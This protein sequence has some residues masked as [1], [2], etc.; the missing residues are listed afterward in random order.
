VRR[1][2]FAIVFTAAMPF[3]YDAHAGDS[4]LAE[5]L[6]RQGR[7]L[8][9]KG[10]YAA[11][12][13]RL[14]ESY[15][16][17]PSTGTLLA[18]ALC[19]ER[20]GK[21]ASA[22]ASYAEVVT[23]SKR[24]GNADRERAAREHK[25][26]L[27]PKLSRLTIEVGADAAAASELVVTRD[28]HAVGQGA[29]GAPTPLDPGDHVVMATA[30]GKQA[31]SKTVTVG[32]A[33]DS[34][35]VTVPPLADLAVAATPAPP[36][37][38]PVD[39]AADSSTPQSRPFFNGSPLQTA[40]LVVAGAG[41]VGLGVS[42]YFGLHASGLNSDSNADGHCDRSGCDPYGFG[43]RS[44]AADAS[45]AATVFL[46]AGAGLTAAGAT[47]FFIG[48]SKRAEST[49]IHATPVVAPG[50]AAVSLGGQF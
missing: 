49:A 8:M 35:T 39:V 14:S 40:G 28:G 11:A 44:D 29:W 17:D 37:T 6:F 26:A 15:V 3:S 18:L 47:L 9:D 42:A 20:A 2:L 1:A 24:E 7:A 19:Q 36:P 5:S 10:D 41:V 21:T 30:S 46:L 23:R 38:P 34:Q 4:V 27:E 16:Q 25:D 50:V 12:C 22:W 43:K 31:W 48:G 32:A 13:P 33:A 45:S